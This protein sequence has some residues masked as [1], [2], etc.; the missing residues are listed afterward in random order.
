MAAQ[1]LSIETPGSSFRSRCCARSLFKFLLKSATDHSLSLVFIFMFIF[2]FF[3]WLWRDKKKGGKF[4]FLGWSRGRAELIGT[5]I[6][7]QPPVVPRWGTEVSLRFHISLSRS[8]LFL[9]SNKKSCSTET[10][11]HIIYDQSADFSG[12]LHPTRWPRWRVHVGSWCSNWR[13]LQLHRI[14]I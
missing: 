11:Q 8:P 12:L 14:F 10:K 13:S 6:D 7:P 1:E 2:F 3:P 5:N 4:E 9:F